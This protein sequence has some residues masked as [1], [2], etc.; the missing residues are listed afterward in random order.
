M[1]PFA[2]IFFA[3]IMLAGQQP[4]HQLDVDP[5]DLPDIQAPAETIH[6]TETITVH[7]ADAPRAKDEEALRDLLLQDIRNASVDRGIVDLKLRA[8]IRALFVKLQTEE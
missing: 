1:G 6:H 3:L 5:E 8:S 2:A 7:A 4:P